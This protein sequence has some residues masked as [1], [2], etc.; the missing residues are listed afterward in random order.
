MSIEMEM[1]RLL[2]KASARPI[3]FLDMDH[4]LLV[5]DSDYDEVERVVGGTD[6]K[7]F[8]YNNIKFMIR[9]NA[10]DLING[11]S[12]MGDLF[13]LTASDKKYAGGLFEFIKS[14]S[15]VSSRF[16]CFGK[17]KGLISSLNEKMPYLKKTRFTESDSE[18]LLQSYNERPYIL[19]DD[20]NKFAVQHKHMLMLPEDLPEDFY[21]DFNNFH[22][23]VPKF[24]VSFSFDTARVLKDVSDKL[25]SQ[26]RK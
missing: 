14:D 24:F 7:Y 10:C 16:P 6:D 25:S 8:I 12:S 19:L 2:K 4:T 21:S 17:I 5:R 15:K 22:V 1:F 23:Q 26:V 9:E 11:L 3:I 13:I 18:M 20:N